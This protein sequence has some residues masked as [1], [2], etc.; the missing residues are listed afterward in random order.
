MKNHNVS[1]FKRGMWSVESKVAERFR[2][3]VLCE[4]IAPLYMVHKGSVT[5]VSVSSPCYF[6]SV[7]TRIHRR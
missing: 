6:S 5:S 1:S 3:D 2:T 7:T 4:T